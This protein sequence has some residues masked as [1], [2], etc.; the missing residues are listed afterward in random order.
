MKIK[1]FAIDSPHKRWIHQYKGSQ[2]NRLHIK[3]RHI[4][5]HKGM[6]FDGD[7]YVLFSS[8]SRPMKKFYIPPKSARNGLRFRLTNQALDYNYQ[9]EFSGIL[10]HAIHLRR[11]MGYIGNI[12]I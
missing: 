10:E 11:I 1:K 2:S 7:I 5:I 12:S 9:P 8:E 6:T 4:P 3:F